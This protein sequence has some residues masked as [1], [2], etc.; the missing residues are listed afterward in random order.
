L[1]TYNFINSVGFF[2][3]LLTIV[4]VG[5]TIKKRIP[6]WFT[7]HQTIIAALIA[8]LAVIIGVNVEILKEEEAER[9]TRR[10]IGQALMLEAQ[11]NLSEIRAICADKSKNLNYPR[12]QSTIYEA[13]KS[14]LLLFPSG[15][16]TVP[17]L[18]T[19][20]GELSRRNRPD[21]DKIP[22]GELFEG[23]CGTSKSILYAVLLNLFRDMNG[24][25]LPDEYKVKFG[26]PKSFDPNNFA[27]NTIYLEQQDDGTFK[28]YKP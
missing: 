27:S 10:A 2:I 8:F 28:V 13:Y 19:L 3:F 15:Y 5:Y 21:T 14:E 9:R 6:K 1:L 26:I 4:F 25:E 22:S 24:E 17:I 16:S 18:E 23:V 7:A 11:R 12:Y 20:F